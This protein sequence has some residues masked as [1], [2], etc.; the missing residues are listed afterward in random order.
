MQN[1]MDKLATWIRFVGRFL[2]FLDD[3]ESKSLGQGVDSQKINVE[4]GG[5]HWP[6]KVHSDGACAGFGTLAYRLV[7][8]R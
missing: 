4:S 5:N 1:D 3:P 7:F 2:D 8:D 6:F